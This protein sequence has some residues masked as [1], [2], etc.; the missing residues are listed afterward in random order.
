VTENVVIHALS[1]VSLRWM[2]REIVGAGVKVL[3]DETA[4][5]DLHIPVSMITST[6][7]PQ[8]Q[9]P[10]SPILAN[11]AE[12]NGYKNRSSSDYD[13]LDAEDVKDVKTKITDQLANV[14]AWWFLEYIPTWF[15]SI[16]DNGKPNVIRR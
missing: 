8:I 14:P 11:R 2:I 1:H 16:D 6:T 5:E 10:A 7:S 15:P 12:G 13:P 3:F 9:D 4:L